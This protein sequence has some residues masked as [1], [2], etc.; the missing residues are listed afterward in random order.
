MENLEEK[1]ENKINNEVPI[2]VPSNTKETTLTNGANSNEN[3]LTASIKINEIPE[4]ILE[5]D[6]FSFLNSKDLFYSVRGVCT[7]WQEIM[8]NVWSSKIK[9]E[10][11]DQVKSLDF[12][13]EKEV[14]T[15]TYEFKLKY[16]MNYRNL[17][18]AYNINANV[19]T[20]VKS[21][22]PL[23][24]DEYQVKELLKLFFSF[25]EM[26]LA[27]AILT[28]ENLETNQN[29]AQTKIE[30]LENFLNNEENY[31]S[32]RLKI[33]EFMDIDLMS[34]EKEMLNL[35]KDSFSLLNKEEL[36][37]LNENAKL[38]HSF[39]QG[40]IE[41][42]ILKYEVKEIRQKIER[43]IMRIQEETE[44][45]P[46][47]K[48]FFEKAYKFLLF[49]KSTNVNIRKIMNIYEENKIRHPLVDFNDEALRMIFELKD[50]LNS[51]HS[52]LN[53]IDETI[54]DNI[55]CRRILL[56]KK[57]IIL[58]KFFNI[59]K[60]AKKE[61]S[62]D[63]FI[64]DKQL[65][66]KQLLWC[67]K[68]SSNSENE[69]LSK[70]SILRTKEYLDENFDYENHIIYDIKAA[71]NNLKF[72]NNLCQENYN[73]DDPELETEVNEAEEGAN[74]VIQKDENT[75]Q[76]TEEDLIR[77]KKEKE[78]LESQKMKT[79][80]ILAMIKKFMSLKEHMS[81]NKKKYKL[82]LYVLSKV[83]KGETTELNQENLSE[84]L[85]NID[86]E[87]LNLEEEDVLSNTEKEE[88][89]N[90]QNS[91]ELLKDIEEGILKQIAIHLEENKKDD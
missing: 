61:N 51:G 78:R 26:N 66:L 82:I 8:K 50:K 35:F 48:R 9:D 2:D 53:N 36:E 30:K 19:L 75:K 29:L 87:N 57:L 59:Y 33:V 20:I 84:A 28:D 17:L 11:I 56:T 86:I 4:I 74:R 27:Y 62:I 72:Q 15:K 44:T 60:D 25:T 46:R 65:S 1:K 68:F 76:Y 38:I 49:S 18:S 34:K 83:R 13:Y 39:L 23:A 21:L 6:I 14:Y 54:F 85:N 73:F 67:M 69:N 31:H 88:L 81:T 79:E 37:N 10:M 91:E 90:F 16:L 55:L 80:E 12:I 70:E 3:I 64:D 7:E 24:M 5:N 41:F 63:F 45:W 77:L 71:T 40:L 52:N 47:K 43:L 89:S 32:F 22:L 42:H 58:E